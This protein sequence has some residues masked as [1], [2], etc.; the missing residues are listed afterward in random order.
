MAIETLAVTS[1]T[2]IPKVAK[3]ERDSN[4][5]LHK[6][7]LCVYLIQ[8]TCRLGSKCSFA[9][10]LADVQEAPNLHKT[11]LCEDYANGDCT[12][13]NCT[14]AHGEEELR[15]SPNFKNKM[16][17]WFSQGKCRNGSECGFAHGKEELRCEEQK[18]RPPIGSPPG[19]TL[20]GE[21]HQKQ[22]L[23][24]SG[25]LLDEKEPPSLEQQVE[26]M[27]ATISS[28]Q[29]KMDDMLLHTQVTGMKQVL[30]DLSAQCAALE[31]V[32]AKP[33]P[34]EI[35]AANAPWK[36]TPLKTKLSSKAQPFNP[37]AFSSQAASF[38]PSFETYQSWTTGCGETYWPS[39]ES[40]DIGSGGEGFFSD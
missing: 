23:N 10:T 17:K 20:E 8:G 31:E 15:L 4:K 26:G 29:R 37:M 39:D 27:S 14:F 2:E 9:H 22:V 18:S 35:L 7:K 33:E 19:L 11:Q 28:L 34:T 38:V 16:C 32:L 13:E 25:N 5:W 36:K 40:T 12:N 1:P 30:G 24:L 6:T 3:K 21:A